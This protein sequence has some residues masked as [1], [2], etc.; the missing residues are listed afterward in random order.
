MRRP[1]VSSATFPTR[2][3]PLTHAFNRRVAS[4]FASASECARA[5]LVIVGATALAASAG[6]Q[7]TSAAGKLRQVA[8]QSAMVIDLAERHFDRRD[9]IRSNS[10]YN[11][12]ATRDGAL[13]AG[14]D[15]GALRYT[16]VEW[17]TD[18][19]P[20]ELRGRQVREVMQDQD[21]GHWFATR[22]GVW[23]AKDTTRR[24]FGTREGL[25]DDVAYSLVETRA[26]DGQLRVAAG[27]RSGVAYFDGSRF[28]TLTFPDA[29]RG[30]GMM[31]ADAPHARG[32]ALWIASADGRVA[33]FVR[34][35]WTVF[36]SSSGLNTSSAEMLFVG[37]DGKPDA[38]TVAGAD[39]V[40]TLQRTGAPGGETER[41]VRIA[42]S[43]DDAYRIIETRPPGRPPELWVGT[44]DGYLFRRVEGVWERV[45]SH[46]VSG[47][48]AILAMRSVPRADGGSAVF[49]AVGGERLSRFAIGSAS[50]LDFPDDGPNESVATVHAE[51][52]ADGRANL[53][54]GSNGGR[55][56][57]AVNGAGRYRQ[58]THAKGELFSNVHTIM[59]DAAPS[60]DGA[61]WIGTDAGAFRWSGSRWQSVREGMPPVSVWSIDR[62]AISSAATGLVA[63]SNVGLFR[64]VGARWQLVPGTA[65]QSVHTVLE[66]PNASSMQTDL[67][68]HTTSG[69]WRLSNDTL[70]AAGIVPASGTAIELPGGRSMCSMRRPGGGLRLFVGSSDGTIYTRVER[71]ERGRLEHDK[72]WER[73]PEHVV[74]ATRDLN[75]VAC[76]RDGRL[77]VATA[78]GLVLVQ[79]GDD[80]AT[81][82]KVS[83]A[84]STEDGLPPGA[85]LSIAN[86]SVNG[87][88]FVGTPNGIGAVDIGSA[89]I[90][91]PPRLVVQLHSSGRVGS[92]DEGERLPNGGATLLVRP[93]LDTDHREEASRFRV[94][95]IPLGSGG[96]E[97]LGQKVRADVPDD[98]WTDDPARNYQALAPGEYLLRVRGRDFVGREAAPFERRF[99]VA[100]APW[101]SPEAVLA[102]FVCLLGV[103]VGAHLWRVAGVQR[104][105]ARVVAGEARARASERRFRAL[106]DESIDGHLLASDGI[107]TAAN[108][109]AL[110]LFNVTTAH[111]LLGKSIAAL[112][113]MPD[114]E[115]QQG[116][117]RAETML[118][119]CDGVQIPVSFTLTEIP[120]D[121]ERLE[122]GVLRDLTAV[123]AAEQERLLLES[124]VR[125][126][127]NLESLGTLAGG[128]AHDF[129]NLLG[130]IRGNAELAQMEVSEPHR[131]GEHLEEILDASGRARDLVRQILTFSRRSSQ[132][133]QQVDLSQLVRDMHPMLRRILPASVVLRLHG[134]Q[135]PMPVDGDATQLQQVLLNLVSN[136]EYALRQRASAELDITLH[137]SAHPDEPGRRMFCLSVRDNGAG[138]PPGVRERVFEP[139]FSTKPTG[140][141]TGLGLAVLHGVVVS[142]RGLI[143]VESEDG[144]GTTFRVLLPPSAKAAVSIVRDRTPM[145]TKALPREATRTATESED[146][147]AAPL[148]MAHIVLVDDEPSV[149]RVVDRVL[150][151]AGHLVHTFAAPADALAFIAERPD[152][153][154]LLMTDQ[155]M[156]GMTGD[157]L[158][159]AV[160]A[161]RPGLPVLILTGFSHRLTDERL[162]E[163]G[164]MVL[165]K[166]VALPALM[167]AVQAAL[168]GSPL[169]R[170]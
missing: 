47:R 116:T 140:E 147:V 149:A 37:L 104:S 86:A 107:V 161:L 119:R 81:R 2:R 19:T 136:A 143:Q 87:V 141:G 8:P 35:A 85:V 84:A 117:R 72:L 126:A 11:V 17:T 18:G 42:G 80:D 71:P 48:G 60:G 53:W 5:L 156:P 109:A 101:R 128:V 98:E 73:V 158:A 55:G 22:H 152:L 16:G 25:A 102:Y 44:R 93:S 9:G 138:M 45:R 95:L 70:I 127:Q 29:F 115:E 133:S 62:V 30:V 144:K 121:E 129:N 169:A 166:P 105:H 164:A 146:D 94:E 106:F 142:H 64:L 50:A 91:P 153:P 41:F 21:G 154:D 75:A 1:V 63:S 26:I 114:A 132:D 165:Q 111:G 20:Q 97:Q 110:E 170:R 15:D 82:W 162:E 76:E 151:R 46:L 36:D 155:T 159:M 31:L 103:A 118:V 150:S 54:F 112:V 69:V 135:Q 78:H 52:G 40:F 24:H 90:G 89:N 120:G 163:V 49:V 88:H 66:V 139:F 34:G 67:L 74:A 167:E 43:P 32:T 145:H 113:P 122:H 99:T 125:E 157:A 134:L 123:R 131:V 160:R 137:E 3:S 57:V 13:W 6:A 7:Q 4:A 61:L 124:R 65:K 77:L 92:I 83:A 33:R 108:D 130:V 27:T 59:R 96:F 68:L 56:I 38:V 51:A 100:T 28:R 10:I 79:T 148:R 12:L 39:G 58:F 168:E 14:T 23:Y